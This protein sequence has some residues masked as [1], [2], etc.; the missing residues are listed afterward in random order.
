MKKQLLLLTLV[1]PTT[2]AACADFGWPPP[3]RKKEPARRDTV[4][5]MHDHISSAKNNENF[6]KREQYNRK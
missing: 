2:L 5:G 4:E 6:L 1:L 3:D